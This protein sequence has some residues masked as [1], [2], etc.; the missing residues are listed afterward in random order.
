MIN[1]FAI[2]AD[3]EVIFA[4]EV[5]WCS[6]YYPAY[7]HS[8]DAPDIYNPGNGSFTGRGLMV[9]LSLMKFLSRAASITVRRGVGT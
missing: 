5:R 3:L 9:V 6:W 1:T 7:C 8:I 4:S 2:S